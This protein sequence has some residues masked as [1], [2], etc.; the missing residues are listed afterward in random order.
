[1]FVVGSLALMG[2]PF[3]SGYYSKDLLMELAACGQTLL[4]AYANILGV[5]TAFFTAY[6]SFRLL[7][8]TFYGVSRSPRAYLLRAHELDADMAYPLAVLAIGSIF[9]GY[10]VRDLFVG[11]GSSY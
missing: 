11:F 3:L 6:Y 8:L 5:V 2:F 10:F 9:F 7:K 4:S 1:M